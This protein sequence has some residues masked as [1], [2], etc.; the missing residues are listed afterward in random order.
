MKINLFDQLVT[1]ALTNRPELTSL[2]IVV[3]KELLHHEILRI[4]SANNLLTDLT[5]IGG[6]CLRSCYGGVRLSEDLDFTGG[7]NFSRKILKNMGQ[8]LTQELFDK[9]ELP[10]QISEPTKDKKNVDTW[11]IKIE[12]KPGK[13]NFPAQRINIDICALPSYE[14]RPM[15]LLNPYGVD[16]GTGGLIINAESRQE[17]YTGK[18]LAF[19]LRPN[20]IKYR[21]VWDIFWLHSLGLKPNL[22][23][24]SVKLNDRKL[25]QHY[26]LDLFTQRQK[27]LLKDTNTLIEFKQEMQR[28]LAG[29]QLNKVINQPH[30]WLTISHLI[31]DLG[32]QIETHL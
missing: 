13:K 11:K 25:T 5:F 3:E 28:F 32:N 24:I 4:L 19:A 14:K 9:Y 29:E 16:M 15:L 21:D 6:T 20:R 8:L 31:E 27:L 7:S 17:I 22:E 30:L 10:I 23:L 12:T 18:L 1:E 26:F 2:R